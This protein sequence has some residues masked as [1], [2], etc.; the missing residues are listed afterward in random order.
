MY[1]LLPLLALLFISSTYSPAPS[2]GSEAPDF[3]LTSPNGK[4]I[5][6]SKF[7]GKMVL[8]DFWASWCGPCR[9][10]NPNVVQVYEKYSKEKF[11][12]GKGLVILSVSLDR[13]EEPWK[14]AI[15][16]D[17]LSWKTHGWDKDGSVSRLYGVSS[18]P[19]AFL[20]DG[21]GKIVA[22]GGDVRGMKLH[23]T[24]DELLKKD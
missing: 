3:E 7:R 2:V 23:L 19:M 8:V 12:N 6:L 18:I 17:N 21:D 24:L 4:K 9:R 5:K 11:E 14:K 20:I 10:E 15:E 1:R 13:N 16:S 22:S